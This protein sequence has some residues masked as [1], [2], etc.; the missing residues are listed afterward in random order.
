MLFGRLIYFYPL[1]LVALYLIYQKIRRNLGR[2]SKSTLTNN[3]FN[4]PKNEN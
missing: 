3:L 1:G 2:P 4:I